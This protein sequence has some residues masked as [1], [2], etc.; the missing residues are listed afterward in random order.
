MAT[1]TSGSGSTGFILGAIVVVLVGVVWHRAVGAHMFGGNDT[2]ITVT[3]PEVELPDVKVPDA[4]VP[5]P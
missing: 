4:K 5:A 1:E 2:S 3:V